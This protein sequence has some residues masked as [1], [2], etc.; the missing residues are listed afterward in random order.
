MKECDL[1]TKSGKDV[2][3]QVCK[4]CKTN[5]CLSCESDKVKYVLCILCEDYLPVKKVR[6]RSTYN[7]P[8]PYGLLEAVRAGN[9]DMTDEELSGGSYYP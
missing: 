4:G 2:V 3:I 9:G 7:D 1:C 8:D 6:S 5:I